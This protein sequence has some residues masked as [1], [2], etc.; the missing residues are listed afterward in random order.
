[1]SNDNSRI[2]MLMFVD[3]GNDAPA[4][5][6]DLVGGVKVQYENEKNL[7]VPSISASI[8]PPLGVSGRV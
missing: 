4:D 7:C 6:C 8:V 5:C 3:D 2:A 1:M